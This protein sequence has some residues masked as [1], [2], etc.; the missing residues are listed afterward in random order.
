[1]GSPIRG[2]VF[3]SMENGLQPVPGLGDISDLGEQSSLAVVQQFREIV[4]APIPSTKEF[5]NSF[6]HC[7][8]VFTSAKRSSISKLVKP[9]L[10]HALTDY[11][12]L[13]CSVSLA[14]PIPSFGESLW[15]G[16][17]V[18]ETVGDFIINPTHGRPP[19]LVPLILD[20]SPSP[21]KGTLSSC[22]LKIWHFDEE[23]T[24]FK[25]TQSSADKEG[26][27]SSYPNPYYHKVSASL[28][29]HYELAIRTY[30]DRTYI[31]VSKNNLADCQLNRAG[32]DSGPECI[33]RP[34]ADGQLNQA[35]LDSGP[36]CIISKEE[37]RPWS[38]TGVHSHK[39]H[40]MPWQLFPSP[41][42]AGFNSS[43]EEE[44]FPAISLLDRAVSSPH[45]HG[46]AKL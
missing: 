35:G 12:F 41:F 18:S 10:A 37:P 5:L 46:R 22:F 21:I 36:E 20:P 26:G 29:P 6:S 40:L 38:E 11:R 23:F 31:G 43:R 34:L 32:L 33:I 3:F 42:T 19:P 30:M 17:R 45:H 39:W 15:E 28:S 24:F 1:M 13:F 44:E 4:T 7:N 27:C 25:I 9:N 16:S 8:I 14:L 2:T